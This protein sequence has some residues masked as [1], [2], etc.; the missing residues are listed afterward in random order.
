MN[1]FDF[2]TAERSFSVG[3]KIHLSE[4]FSGLTL[5]HRLLKI[6]AKEAALNGS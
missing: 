2:G 6:D 5:G 3:V 4:F 1:V